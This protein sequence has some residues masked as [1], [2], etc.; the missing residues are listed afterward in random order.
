M[1]NQ[2]KWNLYVSITQKANQL[3]MG[4]DAKFTRTELQQI[5]QLFSNEAAKV[6]R[7]LI[8]SKGENT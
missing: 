4:K 7:G 5:A 2:G 8:I 6:K 3:L 1:T